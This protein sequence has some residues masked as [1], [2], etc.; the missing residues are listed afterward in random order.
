MKVN[1]FPDRI[2]EIDTEEF[3][4]FGGTAYLGLPTNV[5]FQKL[6]IQNI[7]IWG[8]AYGSSRNANIKLKAY[9][10][11]ED[12]LGKYIKAESALTI[13]SGMLAGKLALEILSPQTDFFFHFPNT[14]P[15]LRVCNSL[16]VLI[17]NELNP[18]LLDSAIEKI[19]ILTDSVPSFHTKPVD[20]SILNSISANKEITLLVDESHS[21]GILGSNGCGIYSDINLSNIKRKIMIASLGKAFGL[22]GGVIAS[23][24]Q[25][26]NE[27][28]NLDTF[29]SSASMSAAAVQTLADAAEIYVLQHKKLKDNLIYIETHLI[30]N[31]AI[32]FDVNY[33]LMYPEIDGIKEILLTNKIIATNFKYPTGSKE[34]NRIVITANHKK[35]DLDTIIN[36]LN[37]NQ[38]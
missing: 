14:H 3:L 11:G 18:R 27:V 12:F 37:Q 7:L 5:A 33:P 20:F 25:F 1:Q 8:T 6:F 32:H 24:L 23:D 2:I 22:T 36:V 29:I 15:A 4:Y 17:K 9:D 16:P 31:K 34:L 19:T 28:K 30:K 26:I 35:E 10:N 13:S 38:I 21:L